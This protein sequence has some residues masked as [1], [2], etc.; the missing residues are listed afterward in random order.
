MVKPKMVD[1]SGEGMSYSFIFQK[2]IKEPH[3]ANRKQLPP[4]F[5]AYEGMHVNQDFALEKFSTTSALMRTWLL[6]ESSQVD[7]LS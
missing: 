1:L 7:E 3:L 5:K 4:E 2:D 6:F